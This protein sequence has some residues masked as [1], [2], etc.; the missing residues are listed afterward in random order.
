MTP[1]S[2]VRRVLLIVAIVLLLALAWTGISGGISQLSESQTSGQM[3]QTMM[4]IAYG[5]F[6]TLSV[7]TTF[8]ARRWNRLLLA[9]WVVTTSSAAGLASVVWGGTSML[10]GL[11]SGAGACLVALGIAWLLH[12]GATR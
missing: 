9:T 11:F 1:G 8:W 4:Q 6:A 7:A 10:M 2:V 3:A 12:T 5:L